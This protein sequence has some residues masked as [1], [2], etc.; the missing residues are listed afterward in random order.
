MIFIGS[1][2]QNF[3]GTRCYPIADTEVSCPGTGPGEGQQAPSGGVMSMQ[4]VCLQC[5]VLLSLIEYGGACTLLEPEQ[6]LP[7]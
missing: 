4:N 2:L 6:I 3:N 7:A 5:N 1:Q